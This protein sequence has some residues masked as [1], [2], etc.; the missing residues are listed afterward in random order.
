MNP[1]RRKVA[2]VPCFPGRLPIT[3]FLMQPELEALLVLQDRDQKIKVLREQQKS[4]PTAKKGL[5]AKLASARQLFEHAKQRGKEN[6]VERRK[7]QLDVE[8]K[9]GAIARFKTQQQATRKNEEYQALNKEISHFESDIRGLEDRELELME[10]AEEIAKTTATAEKD[11]TKTQSNIQEQIT[12]LETGAKAASDRLGELEADHAKLAGGIGE[13]TLDL[14]KRL[15]VKKG[16]A[17]VVP[18][19]HEICAGCHMKVP[20]QV[21]AVVRARQTIAQCPNCGRML[22]RVV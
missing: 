14:Y 15:L 10:Q 9:R 11:F 6:E 12:K 20:T 17:A 13:D 1:G 7:L 5:E 22:Y 19:E 16:D 18:L 4:L 2:G 21:A 3:I 8:G